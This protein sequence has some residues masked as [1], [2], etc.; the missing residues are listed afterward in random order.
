[1]PFG[2]YT[3]VPNV[4]G[5]VVVA[6]TEVTLT[7][8]N[9]IASDVNYDVTSE[10]VIPTGIRTTTI[11]GSTVQSVWSLSGIQSLARGQKQGPAQVSIMRMSDGTVKKVIMK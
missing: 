9:P 4:D 1:M 7:A 8:G 3:V 5:Y 10:G 11:A 6:P 2:S